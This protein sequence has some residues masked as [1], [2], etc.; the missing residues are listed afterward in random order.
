MKEKSEFDSLSLANLEIE[1]SASLTSSL[2]V[3]QARSMWSH[4]M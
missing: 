2:H 3:N 4:S 1:D